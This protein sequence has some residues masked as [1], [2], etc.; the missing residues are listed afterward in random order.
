MPEIRNS[1]T[2]LPALDETGNYSYSMVTGRSESNLTAICHKMPDRLIP[3]IF[4]PGV[5]GTN[6]KSISDKPRQNG[7]LWRLDNPGT[8]AWWLSRGPVVRRNLLSPSVSEVDGGAV[9]DQENATDNALFPSRRDRH[10]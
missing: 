10:Y 1:V 4:I 5:M 7:G 6:L 3:V 9:I 8:L 2:S